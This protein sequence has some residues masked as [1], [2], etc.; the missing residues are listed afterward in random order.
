[1][2]LFNSIAAAVLLVLILLSSCNKETTSGNSDKSIALKNE[3]DSLQIVINNAWDTMMVEDD[4]KL[5]YMK[6]VLDEAVYVLNSDE[7]KKNKLSAQID[8][9]KNLRY[10]RI[11]VSN[12]NLID[13]YDSA[14]NLNIKRVF[15]YLDSNDS[16]YSVP[17]INDLH[18]EIDELDQMVI[19]R[20]GHYDEP[21][22]HF[23]KLLKE[24][25]K[26]IKKLGEPY[27]S[28][29]PYPLFVLMPDL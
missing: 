12:S 4:V 8:T 13:K 1:M 17:L 10:D 23:N 18:I 19:H 24:E 2:K 9:L 14:T 25:E 27:S 20:R 5:K 11:S 28:L 29:K 16:A 3:I 22:M 6:R 15:D 26:N 21:A 7:A